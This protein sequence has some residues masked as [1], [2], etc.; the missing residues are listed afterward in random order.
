M[1]NDGLILPGVCPGLDIIE[2]GVELVVGQKRDRYAMAGGSL[3][4][5]LDLQFH[6]GGVGDLRAKIL[7]PKG[8]SVLSLIFIK[9][10]VDKFSG[11]IGQLCQVLCVEVDLESIFVD[12]VYNQLSLL[13]SH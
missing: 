3:D 9:L 7:H 4:K 13:L 11:H 8:L 1:V 12:T 10:I 5:T 6:A 2:G